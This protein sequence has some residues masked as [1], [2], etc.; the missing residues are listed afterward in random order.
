RL[1]EAER[2]QARLHV[3]LRQ[4]RGGRAQ[5]V[6]AHQRGDPG[7]RDGAEAALRHRH[8]RRRRGGAGSA[9]GARR[10]QEEL[11]RAGE[12]DRRAG[13]QGARRE[14][15]AGGAAGRHLHHHQRRHLRLHALH[16]HPQ[17]AAGG[18]PGDAQHRGAPRRRER[19]RGDPPHHVRRPHLRPPHRGRQRGGALP[20]DREAD[21]RRPGHAPAGGM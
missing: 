9:R 4:G 12:G 19:L 6:P 1:R 10:G 8:R 16:A 17:P 11:R 20:G 3:V 14:A 18:D 2:D 21:D 13:D 7:R 15:G 5:A